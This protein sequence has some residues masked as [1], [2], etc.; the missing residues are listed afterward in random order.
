MLPFFGSNITLVWL[1][2]GI[3]V[4]AFMRWGY[5]LWPG[6]FIGAWLVNF[7]LGSP[8]W[9][10]TGIAVTNS[11]GP[12]L[13]AYLVG[14]LSLHS[15]LDRVKDILILVIASAMGMFVSAGGGVGSLVLFGLLPSQD[16]ISALLC[17]WAGDFVGVLLATPLLLSFSRQALAVLW[18]QRLEFGIWLLITLA[19]CWVIFFLDF[20][21]Y[22][23]YLPRA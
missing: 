17:W 14:K 9:V 23:A 3:A 10:V 16:A 5:G 12:L 20:S 21:A 22:G 11:L 13:T 15:E 2:T 6:V 1:P 8:L 18:R 4:A 19:L 7:S